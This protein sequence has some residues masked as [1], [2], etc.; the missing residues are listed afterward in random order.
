EAFAEFQRT[1]EPSAVLVSGRSGLG[2]T[3]LVDEFL[4]QHAGR[5]R[6]YAGQCHEQEAVSHKA[7]DEIVDALAQDFVGPLAERV[8]AWLTA[9]EAQQLTRLFPALERVPAFSTL[10]E[11]AAEADPRAMRK[12]A[13]DALR[14]VLSRLSQKLP[15]VL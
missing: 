11:D 14:S 15:L 9:H 10:G 6:V 2:K 8:F 4:R 1:R 3:A 5:A 7:F 12:R 13:Y